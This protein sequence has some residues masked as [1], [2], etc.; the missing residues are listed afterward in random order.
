MTRLQRSSG[1]A[2]GSHDGVSV[3]LCICWDIGFHVLA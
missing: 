1:A 2:A 3:G